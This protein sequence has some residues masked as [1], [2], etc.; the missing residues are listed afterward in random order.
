MQ[1]TRTD[2]PLKN[3]NIALEHCTAS[4]SPL[5]KWEY[6]GKCV[7]CAV[8]S[9]Q[10]VCDSSILY[11]VSKITYLCCGRVVM[12]DVRTYI[13]CHVTQRRVAG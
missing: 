3:K 11:V 5:E 1:N 9:R 2:I 4:A 13:L 6:V 12:F 10:A 8:G 7:V